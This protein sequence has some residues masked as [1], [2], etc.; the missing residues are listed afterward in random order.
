MLGTKTGLMRSQV[1]LR[2]R[3]ECSDGLLPEGTLDSTVSRGKD[4]FPL[5]VLVLH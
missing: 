2:Y 3:Q 4:F 1:F 5:R